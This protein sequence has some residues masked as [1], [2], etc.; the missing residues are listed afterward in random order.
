MA[1]EVTLAAGFLSKYWST[2]GSADIS[3]VDPLIE[4]VMRVLIE[5]AIFVFCCLTH[6]PDIDLGHQKLTSCTCIYPPVLD[7]CA[8]ATLPESPSAFPAVPASP[9]PSPQGVRIPA[10]GEE[11]T[12]NNTLIPSPVSLS[13]RQATSP[14]PTASPSPASIGNPQARALMWFRGVYG[15]GTARGFTGD[16]HVCVCFW[17]ND[18]K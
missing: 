14:S 15:D 18:E 17:Q 16:C 7:P 12:S 9:I 6:T 1:W 8:W 11:G 13:E 4:V 2:V 5:W 10:D 3:R